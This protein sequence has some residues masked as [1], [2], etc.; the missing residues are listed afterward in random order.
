MNRNKWVIAAEPL[1]L[2]LFELIPSQRQ[3][4]FNG[5]RLPFQCT[6]TYLDNTTEVHWYHDGRLV[7]SNEESGMF[8]EESITHDCCLITR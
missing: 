7:E 4:V 5:D 3:V 6:A 2:P 1:E 8:V